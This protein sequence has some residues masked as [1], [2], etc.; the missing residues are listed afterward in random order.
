MS[1][2][3][4]SKVLSL[5]LELLILKNQYD[6]N[7][8][9]KSLEIFSPDN[10]TVFKDDGLFSETIFGDVGSPLRNNR[11][12]VIELNTEILHPWVYSDLRKLSKLYDGIIRGTTTAIWDQQIRDFVA[13]DSD[14]AKTGLNF[15]IKYFDNVTLKN[16]SK[17]DDRDAKIK[18]VKSKPIKDLLVNT[19]AVYPAGLR[20]YIIDKS[21][22]PS[23]DESNTLYRKL[24]NTTNSLLNYDIKL[25]EEEDL[26]N[27][28]NRL[29]DLSVEIEDH[30]IELVKG[31]KKF[32]QNKYAKRGVEF[33]TRNV[34]VSLP[35]PIWDL[36]SQ[37]KISYNDTVV[38]LRQFCKG[39][40]PVV[41]HRI[42]DLFIN[43]I[44][45]SLDTEAVLLNK[46]TMKSELTKI[47]SKLIDSWTSEG[48]N[49]ML[50]SL[51]QQDKYT[52]YIKAGENHY[53]MALYDD[54][55]KV[56]IIYDTNL[57]S[58]DE[59]KFI[60]P[61]TYGEFLYLAVGEVSSKYPGIVT[62]YPVI[63]LGGTYPCTI[64]LKSTI[65][66]RK[67]QFEH[68]H[69]T[70]EVT[71]YD[72]P[73]AGETYYNAMTPHLSRLAR[74]GGDFDGDTMSLIILLSDESIDEVNEL[75]SDPNYYLDTAGDLVF[76]PSTDVID[77][78]VKTINVG[79]ERAMKK[80]AIGTE[81]MFDFISSKGRTLISIKDSDRIRH[82]T[83]IK[84][85]ASLDAF[86]KRISKFKPRKE[87]MELSY[88]NVT[89]IKS[90]HSL[91]A[92]ERLIKNGKITQ[93]E[94]LNILNDS[95]FVIDHKAVKKVYTLNFFDVK[96]NQML[97]IVKPRRDYKFIKTYL[98]NKQISSF[99]IKNS[100]PS[101]ELVVGPSNYIHM[102]TSEENL[103]MLSENHWNHFDSNF[104]TKFKDIASDKTFT[105][106]RTVTDVQK[107]I[108][109][110]K[111]QS[112]SLRKIINTEINNIE[113]YSLVKEDLA[114]TDDNKTYQNC[115]YWFSL[116]LSNMA[117]LRYENVCSFTNILNFFMEEAEDD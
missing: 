12:G 107:L 76:S 43:N 37:N 25:L 45:T 62:R 87:S 54:G 89:H 73:V 70:S 106:I 116:N 16:P 56:K 61:I 81:S 47:E 66:G 82:N 24:L 85:L 35:T 2:Q 64:Y 109:A 50:N 63:N 84:I 18:L 20:D 23:E 112:K 19:L 110:Y 17:S 29:H 91:F 13:S 8:V 3:P 26:T 10:P 78:V 83:N 60:R 86:D 59:L 68:H 22:K 99:V 52:E 72:F 48:I 104:F 114:D 53:L 92:D 21:G 77:N 6:K 42:R 36:N 93:N 113:K 31:K 1:I 51:K 27:I 105:D 40:L 79:F 4:L 32:A 38:G 57:L 102:Y 98:K 94:I 15:F 97:E 58:K 103:T 96:L 14:D 28:K 9:V 71:L 44:F 7:A 55:K 95:Q 49:K 11:P 100:L 67:V 108:D 39:A 5:K 30:F 90:D 117:K 111:E 69:H 33:G 65:K 34:I 88:E 41:E 75:L 80:Q 115:V 101:K 46:K 74:L